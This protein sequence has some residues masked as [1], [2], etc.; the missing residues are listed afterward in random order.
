[1]PWTLVQQR[2][3]EATSLGKR[4][5]TIA[6][7]LERAIAGGQLKAGER[8]PTVR[9]LSDDLGVSATTV[10][11]AY[12]LLRRR[13]LI[14]SAVG[15]G[16]FVAGPATNGSS[17]REMQVV[18]VPTQASTLG[19][20]GRLAAPWRKRALTASAAYLRSAYPGAADCS[21]GR[22]DPALLPL[23]PLQRAWASAIAGVEQ[24]DLQYTGPEPIPALTAAVLPRLAADEVV[25]ESSDLIV[26]SSAQQVMMLSL[27][28]M[29]ELAGP[30]TAKHP[31]VAVEE[32][33]YPTIF[34]AYERAGCR[35]VGVDVDEHGA[36]PASVEAALETGAKIVLFTPRAHNPTGASWTVGR[37][38][39]LADVL[40]EHRD[41][42]VIEDDQFAGITTTRPSSLLDDE[43]LRDRV[44]YIRSFSK[45]IA[46]DLR[47]AVA[48]ARPRLRSLL[49]EA[50]SFTD[51]WTSRLLQRVLAKLLDDDETD[52]LLAFARDA[53]ASRREAVARV[54]D[55][56]L[57]MRGGGV[58][59]GDD[60]VNVWVH[61]PPGVESFAVVERAAA[62]GVIV[63]PGEP[64]YIRP[65]RSDLVRI[66]AG[67][68]EAAQAALA[69]EA[70]V[71]AAT[72]S[73][74]PQATV[75]AV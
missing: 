54:V 33:G 22:P 19:R 60:G 3:S 47:I 13:G 53:Y 74:V 65:G 2:F 39:A 10:G 5:E 73:D 55:A 49:A 38:V 29:A 66:N 42:Y 24:R 70:L 72:M 28:V 25:A 35:L 36:N 69:A 9:Q 17:A 12:K 45:S 21:S 26:G 44:V 1:M 11:A 52:E 37:R 32:P 67:A 7:T 41:V 64:F 40:A 20:R 61:L 4:Y 62:L 31:I 30:A 16:T 59:V 27:E 18:R 58:V 63:A 50:R 51:G 15:R 57:A 43:R 14:E 6:A 71:T 34:D 75:I 56:G 46:P 8:L 23:A 48:V 68:V